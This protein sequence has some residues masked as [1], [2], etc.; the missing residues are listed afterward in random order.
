MR[1]QRRCG[2]ARRISDVPPA[3]WPSSPSGTLP[4]SDGSAIGKRELRS[5]LRNR[6]PKRGRSAEFIPQHSAEAPDSCS[7]IHLLEAE[8]QLVCGMRSGP[9]AR[10]SGNAGAAM[11]EAKAAAWV[12]AECCGINSALHRS[13]PV[14]TGITAGVG[15]PCPDRASITRQARP[16]ATNKKAKR[17]EPLGCF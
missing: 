6:S 15:H 11:L 13:G 1:C 12:F 16:K 4:F 7:R 8:D 17:N 9:H 14:H 3:T 5:S 2:P 10:W